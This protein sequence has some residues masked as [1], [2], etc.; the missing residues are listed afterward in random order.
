MSTQ[1]QGRNNPEITRM[2]PSWKE[3][4]ASDPKHERHL[5]TAEG[6]FA[7]AINIIKNG[8]MVLELAQLDEREWQSYGTINREVNLVYGTKL[9]NYTTTAE[10]LIQTVSVVGAAARSDIDD[11][12]WRRTAFG[13]AL[14]PAAIYIWKNIL[15]DG[16]NPVKALTSKS[17]VKKDTNGKIV[18]SAPYARAE[19]LFDIA[20]LKDAKKIEL[21][22]RRNLKHDPTLRHLQNLKEIGLI[23]FESIDPVD[24]YTFFTISSKGRE[25]KRWPIYKDWN[26]DKQPKLTQDVDLAIIGV[27]EGKE[28]FCTRD[29]MEWLEKHRLEVNKTS[30][31]KN[32]VTSV[33]SFFVSEGM[34][35]ISH[36]NE[37]NMSE[38]SLTDKGEA[39]V[40]HALRPLMSWA[41]DPN[42]VSEINQ[43]RET[44]VVNRDVY[45][46]FYKDIGRVYA[47]TSPQ[48]NADLEAKTD[49]ILKLINNNPGSLTISDLGR[50]LSFSPQTVAHALRPLI[51]S[52]NVLTITGKGGRKYLSIP[53]PKA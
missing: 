6:R 25:T 30:Q 28:N 2:S 14:L 7:A 35:E 39:F 44:L 50:E 51:S 13:T 42:S 31:R 53:E 11:M 19:M 24:T 22:R 27:V 34:L 52:G 33:L 32:S 21:S 40:N 10:H 43:I 48:K 3:I 47:E 4:L 38:V 29:I 45:I 37:K 1:E 46:D 8:A 20:D 12:Q 9:C 41:E 26:A 17:K 5:E 15:E 49:N 36:L 23:N 16:I 18:D